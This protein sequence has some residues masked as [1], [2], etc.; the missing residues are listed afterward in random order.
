M[1]SL[2]ISAGL[3]KKM[4]SVPFG[5]P[6]SNLTSQTE[7]FARKV[8]FDLHGPILN[9]ISPYC[10]LAEALFGVKIDEDSARYYYL[11]HDREFPDKMPLTP[12]Q[13]HVVFDH[14]ARLAKGGFGD[15]DF[16]PG[17]Q[18]MFKDIQAAGIKTEIW[19]YVPGATDYGHDTLVA[20]GTG[21]A[22]STTW[23]LI[24][25]LGLV[26][27]VKR[28]VRFIQPSAKVSAMVEE[29]IPL[30]V[31]D[32]PTTAVEAG[33]N[34]GLAAIVTPHNYNKTLQGSGILRLENH[35]QIA[36][37]VIEFFRQ[38]EEAGALLGTGANARKAKALKRTAG[39]STRRTR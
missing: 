38:M 15:L 14:M 10:R 32:N 26:K 36:V 29:H 3:A 16:T 6:P 30:I 11:A 19:T 7:T 24:A 5:W 21:I 37:A 12:A 39:S 34:Y 35:D 33:M 27:D 1:N 22:Q 20:H 8:V 28:Q 18:Q 4:A 9:W 25:K 23:D 2:K 13:S 31:E 17:I